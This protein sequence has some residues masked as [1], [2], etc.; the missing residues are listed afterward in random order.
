MASH[1]EEVKRVRIIPDI[2]ALA[3]AGFDKIHKDDFARLK[4]VGFYKQKQAPYFMVRIKIS[5]GLISLDQL[6]AVSRM[7]LKFGNGIDHLSTRQD[8]ELHNVLI[9]CGPE[10][11]RDLQAV[12]LTTRGACGDTVRNIVGV[13]CAGVC[14]HEVYNV[15]PLRKHLYDH[16]ITDDTV[17]NLPR[18]FKIALSGCLRHGG[19]YSI[20]DIG[21]FPSK[22]A[23]RVAAEGPGFEFWVGGGL[24]AQPMLAQK[25][26]DYVPAGEIPAA[27]AATVET[28]RLYG[29]RDSRTTA[30]LKFVLKKWGLEKYRQVWQEHFQEFLEKMGRVNFNLKAEPSE[31]WAP[32]LGAP[33]YKQ[34]KKG[35]YGIECMVPLGDARAEDVLALVSFC[36]KHNAQVR[37][38][39]GQNFHIQNL[40]EAAANEVQPL[41]EYYGWRMQD[42]ERSP[43][44]IAC[45]GLDECGKAVFYTKATAKQITHKLLN[46]ERGIP[47]GLTVH[48]SGC[49]NNCGQNSSAAIGF[50]GAL[51]PGGWQK[52]G[53][54]SL[55]LGGTLEGNG[56]VGKMVAAGLDPDSLPR[57][58]DGLVNAYHADKKLAPGAENSTG[59]DFSTWTRALPKE[60]LVTILKAAESGGRG[61]ASNAPA[62][63]GS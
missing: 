12:G 13:P 3:A 48:F 32:G 2:D 5:A 14:P 25:L 30:R 61:T 7:A 31:V 56:A 33:F 21:M 45:V 49:P 23:A 17:L 8:I 18:K 16:F 35:L 60:K 26:L 55:Y 28:H 27:C 43:N 63:A 58:I 36:R 40:T 52:V 41:V 44:V 42:A 22:N 19:Q 9:N 37:I 39:Q 59:E 57:V 46:D 10:L 51:R 47:K 38:T 4:W 6:A 11:L 50:M 34:K 54:Y 53:V 20:N 24:G 29:N 15:E 1:E 62:A